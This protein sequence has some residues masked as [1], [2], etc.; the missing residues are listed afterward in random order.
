MDTVTMPQLGESV[1]E[2]TI[3]RWLKQPGDEVALDEALCEIETEK[4]TTELPSALAGTLGEILVPE[5][6]TVEVGAALC[7]I[8]DGSGA[9]APAADSEQRVAP[10]KPVAATPP[11]E[12][13]A[14][15]VES[16]EDRSRVYSPVVQRL[17]GEHGIDLTAIRGSG[18]GGRVTRKDVQAVID[19]GGAP[20]PA[21]ERAPL[22]PPSPG[23]GEYETVTSSATRR[24]IAEHLTRSSTEAPQAWTMVEAD[25]TGLVA[26]REAERVRFA[27]EEGVDL[28][29]LPYF[30]AAVAATLKEHPEMN[31]RWAGDELRRYRAINLG[32]A[33]ATERGLVVPAV[34]DAGD[35]N[36]VGL[37]KR[38]QDVVERAHAGKL[39]LDDV[40][41]G[42]FTVNNTGSFGSIASKP[43]VNH[44]EI[45]IV[46]MERIVKR[47]VVVD[48]DAIAV[49]SML[50]VCL[51]F[52]HRA[53]DGAEAGAFLASLRERLEAYAP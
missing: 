18:R 43:L 24:T 53:L 37:A 40:G 7:T 31:A 3:L 11:T 22:T 36:V 5:G 33:I 23:D 2:G 27:E 26:L 9:A 48:D 47:P 42:T 46:S 32:I 50:N 39:R 35:L 25:V 14:A 19:A 41:S 34:R 17:A 12:P 52:D 30:A 15:A 16:G 10:P 20:A 8:G 45:G 49:R 28:T 6:E 4:V 38:I 29:V 1:T 21:P 51:S 44:P 13:V